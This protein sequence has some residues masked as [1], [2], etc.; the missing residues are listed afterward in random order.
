MNFFVNMLKLITFL[1]CRICRNNIKNTSL[2]IEKRAKLVLNFKNVIHVL[3]K[4]SSVVYLKGER[5][6]R[7][8]SLEKKIKF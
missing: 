3:E 6:F 7:L 2:T 1:H 8:I 5:C 4:E